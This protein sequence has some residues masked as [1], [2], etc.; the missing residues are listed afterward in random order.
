[1]KQT[2]QDV[3]SPRRAT[4]RAVREIFWESREEVGQRE[5][6]DILVKG[7]VFYFK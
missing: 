3:E 1:M 6:W 4:I 7:E 5:S 2:P